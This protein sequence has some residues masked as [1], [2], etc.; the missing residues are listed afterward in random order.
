MQQREIQPGPIVMLGSGETLAS[1][2]KV[3]EFVAQ[4]LPVRP[5]ITI[6][7][8][9][10]GFEP[11][12][13]KVAGKI[14]TFLTRRLQNYNPEITVV[15]ARNR[16]MADDREI[17][18]PLL[19]ADQ[20]LLGPGSP[21]YGARQLRNSL[22]VE[23]MFVRQCMGA[24][25]FLSSSSTLAFSRKTMPV[26]EIYKVGEELHWK[27]GVDYFTPF[28]LNIVTIPHWD[29]TDG[30]AELD[31]RRCYMGQ[32]RFGRLF[33]ML[34]ADTTVIGIDEHTGLITD[35]EEKSLHVLGNGTVTIIRNGET[36]VLENGG[37]YSL[38]LLG[39][40]RLP[41]LADIDLDLWDDVVDAVSA[42]A[43]APTP[44]QEVIALLDER[45]AV[46]ASK[47]WQRSDE[48]RD[49]IEALG[50]RV[51]DTPQGAELEAI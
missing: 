40:W 50:W 43:S 1:S 12:S 23:M 33:D 37:V 7:E 30:G 39:A 29:N 51:L 42:K 19:T 16:E 11:N 28:G 46:R 47:N 45:T 34:P 24:T 5:H 41:T 4:R 22:A 25:L 44:T 13:D 48:L 26:Y 17:V 6:M 15:P 32:E 35:F 10:A 27:D 31:T 36:T 38:D 2:G 8:T 21:T 3:H 49:K 14:A 18:A 9:P 20:V